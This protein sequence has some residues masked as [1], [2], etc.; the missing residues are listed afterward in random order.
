MDETLTET[1]A[2]IEEKVDRLLTALDRFLPLIER[3]LDNPAARWAMNRKRP[4]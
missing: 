1:A 3:A 2:R 4:L